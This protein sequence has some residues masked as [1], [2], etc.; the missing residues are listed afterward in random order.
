M[1]IKKAKT[2]RGHMVQVAKATCS[3]AISE[4]EA[5][6]AL[7]AEPFQR[8]HGSIMQDLEEQVIQEESRS[9]A[10]FLTTC[11]V[12][13]YNS[14]PELKS[15]LATSY[16]ILLGQTPLSPPH[17]LLQRT[18]PVEGQLTST[19]PPTPA[20]KQ[21]PRP[22]RWHPSPDLVESM[23]LGRTTSKATPVGLPAPRGERYLPGSEHSSQAMP[24]YLAGTLTW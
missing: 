1:V 22:K 10:N 12:T 20:P 6:C 24:R 4:V 5:Q 3:K 8:E 9:W 7:Q 17:A 18:S 14:P 21:S 2:T 23:P 13:L 19:A 16:H 11:Q 15:T